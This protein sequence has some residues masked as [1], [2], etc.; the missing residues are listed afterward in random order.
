MSL[1]QYN[2]LMSNMLNQRHALAK[3]RAELKGREGKLCRRCGRFGHLT[4]N[5]RSGKE[6]KKGKV[7]ENRFEVLRSWVMQCGVREVRRQETVREVVKCFGYG[8][9]GHK[10]WECSRKKERS[11]SEEVAPPKEI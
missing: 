2:N 3:L 5:C 11:K 4:Q 9:K 1:E 10:K 7:A 8:K 6:Q